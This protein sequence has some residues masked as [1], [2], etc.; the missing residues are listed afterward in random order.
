MHIIKD[1]LPTPVVP[2][3]FRE[4]MSSSL[5]VNENITAAVLF[6]LA[7]FKQPLWLL[8]YKHTQPH[9]ADNRPASEVTSAQDGG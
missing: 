4:V 1:P 7:S 6:E 5:V 8:K 9:S 3:F 2:L